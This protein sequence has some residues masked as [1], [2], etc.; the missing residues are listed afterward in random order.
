MKIYN[1]CIR[2]LDIFRKTFFP[3]RSINF[4]PV[5]KLDALCHFKGTLRKNTYFVL[6]FFFFCCE[7][8]IK[9]LF[10]ESPRRYGT[11]RFILSFGKNTQLNL[12][13]RIYFYFDQPRTIRFN[14]SSSSLSI[15]LRRNIQGYDCF[16]VSFFRTGSGFSFIFKS[17]KKEQLQRQNSLEEIESIATK[18]RKKSRPHSM[19]CS[20]TI[21]EETVPDPVS[22]FILNFIQLLLTKLD[23]QVT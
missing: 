23:S 21:L 20:P 2:K 4:S 1:I 13:G 5:I 9:T 3:N 10:E 11:H 7:N 14:Y 8:A 19:V 22:F 6:H 15:F 16:P 18:P 12:Y 17:A